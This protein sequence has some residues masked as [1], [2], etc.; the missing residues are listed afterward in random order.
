MTDNAILIHH[1]LLC[2]PDQMERL[3]QTIVAAVKWM[4]LALRWAEKNK[5][6]EIITLANAKLLWA[7]QLL[8][9]KELI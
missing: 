5:N 8:M 6:L 1:R 3:P 2:L 4:L 7:N 9:P